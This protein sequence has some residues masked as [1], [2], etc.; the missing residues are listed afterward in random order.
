MDMDFWCDP[1]YIIHK[2]QPVLVQLVQMLQDKRIWKS[3]NWKCIHQQG[4][5]NTILNR[6][7]YSEDEIISNDVNDVIQM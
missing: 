5:A 6:D 1:Y 2:V 4:L 3:E 7:L